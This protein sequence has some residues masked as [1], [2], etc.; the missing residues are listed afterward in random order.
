MTK[1]VEESEPL[2]AAVME[3]ARRFAAGQMTRARRDARIAELRGLQPR[4]RR[5]R[6]RRPPDAD[7]PPV[8]FY[9]IDAVRG[10]RPA[11]HHS[12]TPL[13]LVNSR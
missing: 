10:E 13:E 5:K 4:L 3:V 1:E 8:T 2:N 6:T 9:G 7:A 11:P 12:S